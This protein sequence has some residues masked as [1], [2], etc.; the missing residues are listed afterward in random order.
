MIAVSMCIVMRIHII[1][2]FHSYTHHINTV[3]LRNIIFWF[4]CCCCCC[5]CCSIFCHVIF[6]HINPHI[7][8]HTHTLTKLFRFLALAEHT[9]F[10]PF[11]AFCCRFRCWCW[12]CYCCCLTLYD[13]LIRFQAVSGRFHMLHF[14]PNNL[15]CLIR[16]FEDME[17]TILVCSCLVRIFL[18]VSCV[19]CLHASL[20][21][22]LFV[23]CCLLAMFV[24]VR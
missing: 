22:I 7:Q 19:W 2:Q 17:D 13:S 6:V 9:Q 18:N 24:C 15:W 3:H 8:L 14:I 4:S 11:I 23:C 20:D 10:W 21:Q 1:Y 12:W 16:L 5:C